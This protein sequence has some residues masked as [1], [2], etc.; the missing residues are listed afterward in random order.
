MKYLK[1]I[2]FLA[3]MLTQLM[4]AQTQEDYFNTA[5][6]NY[7][8]G[9]YEKALESLNKV[10]SP[11]FD[12]SSLKTQI[13]EK[14]GR[15]GEVQQEPVN[16][17][18]VHSTP[19]NSSLSD[20]ALSREP[21][22]VH[23]KPMLSPQVQSTPNNSSMSD[24]ELYIKAVELSQN[25]EYSKA[26][27]LLLKINSDEIDVQPILDHIAELENEGAVVSSSQ[28]VSSVSDEE[29]YFKALELYQNKEYQKALDILET[30]SSQ[31]ID[32]EPLKTQI[33]KFLETPS[34]QPKPDEKVDITPFEYKI[35]KKNDN[36]EGRSQKPDSSSDIDIEP[37]DSSSNSLFIILVIFAAL[38]FIALLTFWFKQRQF[39]THGSGLILYNKTSGQ[40]FKVTKNLLSIGRDDSCD[41]ILDDEEVSRRHAEIVLDSGDGSY[42]IADLNSSNGVFVNG[43]KIN[44][45]RLYSG[46]NIKIGNQLIS[47]TFS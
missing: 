19:N 38:L 29:K 11:E 26:K 7:L 1:N 45:S 31:E 36:G 40:E 18:Q 27:E 42:L 12:V 46:D 23:V 41:I 37:N 43:K 14:L 32:T 28:S 5:L 34:M 8:D 16:E 10:T 15:S 21:S 25:G 47:V 20:D 24:D 2:L 30:I 33:K 4:I 13:L 6:D 17:S 3:V 9:N 35:R 39:K 44:K 22:E